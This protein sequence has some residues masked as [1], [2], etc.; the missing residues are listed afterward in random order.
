MHKLFTNLTMELLLF[1]RMC[2]LEP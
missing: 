1:K 2:N